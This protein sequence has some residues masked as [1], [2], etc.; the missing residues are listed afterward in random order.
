M[1]IFVKKLVTQNPDDYEYLEMGNAIIQYSIY[2]QLFTKPE[3]AKLFDYWLE[4]EI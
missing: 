2:R 4:S 3:R 1:K